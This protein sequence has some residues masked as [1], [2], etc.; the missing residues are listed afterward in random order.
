MRAFDLRSGFATFEDVM[1]RSASGAVARADPSA[2]A[3]G[4]SALSLTQPATNL[5]LENLYRRHAAW[6]RR[7]L[8]HRFGNDQ[9]EDLSHE[10]FARMRAYSEMEVRHPKSLLLRIAVNVAFEASRRLEARVRSESQLETLPTS[11]EDISLAVPPSQDT[12]LLL[13]QVI[14]SLPPILRDVLVLSRFEGLTYAEIS[15]RLGIPIKTVEWR[16]TKALDI[17][18]T[19]LRG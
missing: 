15:S 4:P 5:R 9:A 3:E 14:T 19:R 1:S 2:P 6:L 17:C 12:A 16:M 13:K 10:A 7:V 11:F 18:A 8:G